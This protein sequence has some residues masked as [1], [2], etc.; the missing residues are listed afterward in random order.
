M[1][2]K[3]VLFLPPYARLTGKDWFRGVASGATES[4]IQRA[5]CFSW[6]LL[7]GGHF[8]VCAFLVKIKK[9][10]AARS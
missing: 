9:T 7:L 5:K 8:N 6:G 2:Q 10:T 4:R 1:S 3:I